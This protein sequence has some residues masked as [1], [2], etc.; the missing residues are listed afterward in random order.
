MCYYKTD[1]HPSDLALIASTPIPSI[2]SW[3]CL[4]FP[5]GTVELPCVMTLPTWLTPSISE[6]FQNTKIFQVQL[7]KLWLINSM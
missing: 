2:Q 7:E 1:L 5:T 6:N 3:V 4:L